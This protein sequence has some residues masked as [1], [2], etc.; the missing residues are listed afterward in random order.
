[1]IG[2]SPDR[3]GID[4]EKNDRIFKG[5]KLLRRFSN[6]KNDQKFRELTCKELNQIFLKDWVIK[7]ACY[8]WQEEKN[9][10]DIFNWNSENDL[11]YANKLQKEK[12]VKVNFINYKFW[13]ISV[14]SNR[15]ILT[16]YPIICCN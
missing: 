2:W 3:I 4:I 7:E 13:Y 5:I 8:K 11:T 16:R 14:A 9:T 6:V 12:K 1:M 10:F 15:Q